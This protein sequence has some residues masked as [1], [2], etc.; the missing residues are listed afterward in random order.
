MS[1]NLLENLA[2]LIQTRGGRLFLTGGQVRNNLRP[3]HQDLLLSGPGDF[4]LLAMGLDLEQI[5][6]TAK[7]FGRARVVF[8]KG[9]GPNPS[10]LVRLSRGPVI[11]EISLPKNAPYWV[12]NFDI[13]KT[14]AS[15]RD[16]TVN[17]VYYDPLTKKIHDPL[18]GVMANAKKSLVL[19]SPKALTADPVRMLRAMV[20]IARRG[21]TA[22]PD[23]LAKVSANWSQLGLAAGDRLWPEWSRWA[24]SRQPHLGLNFL[25]DSGLINFWPPL[26]ALIQIHQ[27]WHC[28][29]EGT[30]W[31]HTVLVVQAMSEL[32]LPDP[33][34]RGVL[35]LAALL[36]D[37]GKPLVFHYN[38]QGKPITRGHAQVGRPV[39]E[40]FLKSLVTPKKIVKLVGKLVSLHMELA[41]RPLTA[42][43]LRTVAR[44][45][46]PHGNLTDFWAVTASDWNGRR[47]RI[48]IYP[49]SL[50]E[51]L[52]PVNG[53]I[54]AAQP[55]LK[56]SDLIG[57]FNY[58]PGPGLGE[59]IRRL[60][61]AFDQGEIATVSEAREW[62]RLKAGTLARE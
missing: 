27:N 11:L 14:D 28:H 26:A 1:I 42:K 62:V 38:E 9:Q 45:L 60:N 49:H 17:A 21:Y 31:N 24:F 56:G 35:T 3:G 29:P 5:L 13:L 22:S 37:V 16:F 39:A 12:K 51:F 33:A 46:A 32:T 36:H 52:E 15:E 8:R 41:F 4:D 58:V 25:K 10:A 53:E 50:A 43:I 20:L 55:L 6:E 57:E 19:C 18:M 40:R 59:I 34:R 61:A 47:P 23:L 44:Q 30:A 7:N 2:R 54:T 48:E